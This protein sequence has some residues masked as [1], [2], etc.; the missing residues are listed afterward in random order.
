MGTHH[1]QDSHFGY[2]HWVDSHFGYEHWVD[3]HFGLDDDPGLDPIFD[4]ALGAASDTV[5][6]DPDL[7]LV[8]DGLSIGGTQFG[9][10]TTS[11]LLAGAGT[12]GVLGA[13][14]HFFY[15]P[16]HGGHGRAKGRPGTARPAVHAAPANLT[17]SDGEYE[18]LQ[19][20]AATDPYALGQP[21]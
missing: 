21:L 6:I 18:A 10:D 7:G 9:L 19:I 8:D 2:E 20:A 4:F 11:L 12:V 17:D 1:W 13:I 16:K 14:R 15:G 5:D 3:S